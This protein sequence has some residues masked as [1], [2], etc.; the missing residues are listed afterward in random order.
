[1]ATFLLMSLAMLINFLHDRYTLEN[2]TLWWPSGYGDP[3]L[4]ELKINARNEH[5]NASASHKIGIRHVALVQEPTTAGNTTGT[6]FYFKVN[7]VPIFIKGANWIPTD[8]FPTRAQQ[9]TVKNLIRSAFE[10]NMN[11]VRTEGC[12]HWKSLAC[13]LMAIFLLQ[14]R[15]WGGG[16]YE[17][18]FFYSECDRLG[19]LIWQELMFACGM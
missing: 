11:M 6:T 10:A 3:Y 2:P 17:S 14:I 4:Y 19:L 13:S 8:S 12:A 1:M 15:V 16:R 5:F 9:S 18:D 7:Q